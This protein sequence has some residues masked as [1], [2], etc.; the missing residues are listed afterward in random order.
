MLPKVPLIAA[1]WLQVK[2]EQQ[3]LEALLLIEIQAPAQKREECTQILKQMHS[4]N[5]FDHEMRILNPKPSFA[6]DVKKRNEV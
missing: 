4:E 2:V 1:R 3:T 5:F 6:G